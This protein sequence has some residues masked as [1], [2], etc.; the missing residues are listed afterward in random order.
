MFYS[1]PKTKKVN[2]FKII[3]VVMVLNTYYILYVHIATANTF[4]TF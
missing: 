1:K 2:L 3:S 4:K